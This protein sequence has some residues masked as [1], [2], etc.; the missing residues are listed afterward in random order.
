VDTTL[1]RRILQQ[2]PWL[3]DPARFDAEVRRRLPGR[4][5]P[6]RVDLAG[7]SD[8]SRAKLIVGPRQSGKSTLVWSLLAGRPAGQ[9]L[10][11]DGEEPTVQAWSGSAVQFISDVGS[12]LQGVR[13]VFIDEAQRLP[14][15]GIFVKGI[16]DARRDLD[17]FVTGSSAFHLASRTGES[18]AGRAVRR[19]LLP[20]SV[21]ELADR[22][23]SPN[24]LVWEEE[25]ARICARQQVY[26]AYPAVWASADPE[27]LLFDLV[28]ALVVRDV[29]DRFRIQR[30]DVFRR[31]LQLAAG[32]IGQMVNLAEWAALLGIAASTVREHLA[33]L[34]EAW[35]LKL[36]PAFAGGR[37][38]EITSAPRVH[39][40]DL[41]IRNALLGAF[42]QDLGVR[43]DRGALAEGWV[44]GE[45]AKNVPPSW[46]VYY[47]RAKGGAEMDFIVCRGDRL[48]AV[49]VKA[50]GRP[51]TSRSVRSFIEAYRPACVVLAVGADVAPAEEAVDGTRV[52]TVPL[53]GVAAAV[54][55]ETAREA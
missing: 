39:Y 29:S 36:L 33:L 22:T 28:E 32:Q 55:E 45:L 31:L 6:R 38:R 35:I 14:E 20:L 54:R 34:E 17:V 16:I 11:L 4:F 30:P 18:L 3:V 42:S 15:A 49:E 8:R 1:R 41:G 10:Y 24:P 13:T 37:R 2:N 48:V 27:P 25:A 21:D 52:R 7:F 19:V 46:L 50:G 44:F 23:T 9:V 12:G 53:H 40:Y 43:P 51:T 47:W 26:G 5:V